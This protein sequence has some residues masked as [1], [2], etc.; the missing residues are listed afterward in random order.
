M[1]IYDRIGWHGL[2][3]RRAAM[4]VQRMSVGRWATCVAITGAT[5]FA[6]GALTTSS[7]KTHSDGFLY[8][9]G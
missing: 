2:A 5:L 7:Q 8:F 6:V 1:P 3:I 9:S 4:E